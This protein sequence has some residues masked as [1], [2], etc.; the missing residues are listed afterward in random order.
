MKEN[1]ALIKA[2]NIGKDYAVGEVNI[3]TLAGVSFEIKPDS[4]Q[5]N[6]Y[7]DKVSEGQKHRL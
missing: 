2:G 1:T 6:K 3:K 7:P 4:S 5:K